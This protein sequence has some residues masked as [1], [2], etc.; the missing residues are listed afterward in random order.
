MPGEDV[1]ENS[2]AQAPQPSAP[3][4]SNMDHVSGYDHVGFGAAAGKIIVMEVFFDLQKN[5][6]SP[7]LGNFL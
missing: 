4:P 7:F 1:H 2:N 6:E 3:D 5:K